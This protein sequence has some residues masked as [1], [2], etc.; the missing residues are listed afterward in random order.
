MMKFLTDENIALSVVQNLRKAGFDVKDVKEEHL[1]GSSDKTLLQLA[2]KEGRALITH[3]KD[4]LHLALIQ[5]IAH[6]GIILIRLKKQLPEEVAQ[7]LLKVLQST[8]SQ[9]LIGAVTLITESR[10]VFH[11]IVR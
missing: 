8:L 6:T 7:R 5:K 2:Q 9:K 4:F 10:V 3:D 1:E 11:T